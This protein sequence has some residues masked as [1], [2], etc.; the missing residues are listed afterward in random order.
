MPWPSLLFSFLLASLYGV[1]F[2]FL[3]GRGWLALG[4]Y[5][6][7]ALIGFALGQFLSRVLSF[8]LLP[9]GAV[10]AIEASVTSLLLLFLTR[11]I[12]KR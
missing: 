9:I 1:T 2:Y 8:S 5:W 3:F 7:V 6:I 10:N 4:V 12:W 11:T